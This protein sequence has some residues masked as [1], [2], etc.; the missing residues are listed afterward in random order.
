MTNN[1]QDHGSDALRSGPDN[2]DR[3]RE[4]LKKQAEK[5]IENAMEGDQSKGSDDHPEQ[6]AAEGSREVIDRDLDR[7]DG[8]GGSDGDEK[9]KYEAPQSSAGAEAGTVAG[10]PQRIAA[11][12]GDRPLGTEVIS[13]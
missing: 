5:G 13:D 10:R 7:Q 12:S 8:D 2:A 9:P 3:A 6:D 11:R 4:D 1:R